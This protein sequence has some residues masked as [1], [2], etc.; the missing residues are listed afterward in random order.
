MKHYLSGRALA[1][2]ALAAAL[3]QPGNAA[4]LGAGEAHALPHVIYGPAV[5]IYPSI[6][7]VYVVDQGP[8]LGLP[9]PPADGAFGYAA[10]AFPYVSVSGVAGP[11]VIYGRP[12]YFDRRP[13]RFGRHHRDWNAERWRGRAV[14]RAPHRT[15]GLLPHRGHGERRR[16]HPASPR[17]IELDGAAH[18]AAGGRPVAPAAPAR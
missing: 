8:Q 4:E 10:D 6:D 14:I 2:A 12:F 9:L 16:G 11:R 15:E 7:P 13:N 5:A 18:P 3:A 1:V 17:V